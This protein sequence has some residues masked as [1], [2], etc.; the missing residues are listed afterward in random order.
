[1]DNKCR[2]P[3]DL[4]GELELVAAAMAP[5]MVLSKGMAETISRICLEARK[6]LAGGGRRGRIKAKWGQ[7]PHS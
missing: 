3:M 6:A 2:I 1:M 5:G 4:G 7:R